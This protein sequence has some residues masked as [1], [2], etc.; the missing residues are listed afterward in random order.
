MDLQQ[1][2]ER[3]VEDGDVP[4]A[5]LG[6][7]DGDEEHRHAAGVLNRRT[8]VATTTDSVFQIGSNT[9]V[10]TATQILQLV[11][12]G[13]VDLDATVRTYLPDF[14]AREPRSAEEL[15]VR[16]LLTHTSGIEGDVF[17]DFGGNDDAIE[18]YVAAMADQGS[19]HDLDETWSYCNSGWVVAGRI[20]EVLRD[21]PWAAALRETIGAPLGMD[22]LCVNAGE[23][24]L[25]RAAVG[26][27]KPP[28]ADELV[29]APAWSL[30]QALAP[31]GLIT[32]TIGDLL[33]FA[34][35][36]LS[37]GAAPD[38]TQVLSPGSV[39][40]MQTPQV[41]CPAHELATH[42]G[43]GWMI[44]QVGDRT[45]IG[46]GGNTIGQS[47]HFVAIPDRGV[48]VALL[49]NAAGGARSEPTEALMRELVADLAGLELPA[50][51]T[52]S[53]GPAVGDLARFAGRYERLG[54]AYDVTAHDGQLE[55]TLTMSGPLAAGS[56]TEGPFTAALRPV[57][58]E[59]SLF[60]M[61]IPEVA[62]TWVPVRFYGEDAGGRTRFLHSG[63]RVTRRVTT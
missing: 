35:M 40:A 43:L 36:H 7:L 41:E 11:D 2:L 20:I 38:G 63:G 51:P 4:G 61:M 32:T 26:H 1:R 22:A 24:I 58:G 23:A 42:W 59:P 34:R 9:K 37:E 33:A 29:V 5:V 14:A 10:W 21:Q 47:T 25:H 57:D 52:P 8:G 50:R 28:G 31:A 55:V 18:R 6:V 3:Y 60:V 56:G 27:V 44:R 39:K 48:A 54:V 53:S 12:E 30:P 15:T 17:D 45:V 16:H 62:E 49:T 13:R 19:V 46:H